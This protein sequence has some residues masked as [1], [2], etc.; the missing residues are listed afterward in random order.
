MGNVNE[1]IRRLREETLEEMKKRKDVLDAGIA[2]LEET[3]QKPD[4]QLNIDFEAIKE[5]ARKDMKFLE[6]CEKKRTGLDKGGTCV[7]RL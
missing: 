3:L 2:R 6:E 5:E 1:T 4:I 7:R